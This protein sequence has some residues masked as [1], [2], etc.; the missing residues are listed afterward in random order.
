MLEQ[1]KGLYEQELANF[2][3]TQDQKLALLEQYYAVCEEIYNRQ[4]ALEELHKERTQEI[5]DAATD[6]FDAYTDALDSV[7]STIQNVINAEVKSG[8]LTE[9]EAKKKQKALKALEAVQLAVAIAS[10][11]GSTA[12]GIMDVW[13]GYAAEMPVNAETAAATGPAAAAT[14][15]ALDAKSLTAAIIKTAAIGTQGTAQI[16]AAIGGYIAKNAATPSEDSGAGVAAT[17]ALIDTTPYAY[18]RT[19]QSVEEEDELRAPIFVT[20]T[21][22]EDG[23]KQRATVTN[24]SSF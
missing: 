2:K 14:K 12:A 17:P 7:L 11:A 21:D 23:L 22:I 20:V 6:H 1:E 3:G 4:E 15:A 9:Q 8:K 19:V 18:T 16:A 24:E 13:R 5:W 10:I